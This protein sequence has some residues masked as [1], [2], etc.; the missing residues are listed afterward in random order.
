MKKTALQGEYGGSVWR[1]N[2]PEGI[3]SKLES[4]STNESW[5]WNECR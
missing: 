2:P 1:L 4:K 3:P 5:I